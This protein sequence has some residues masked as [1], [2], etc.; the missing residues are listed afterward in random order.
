[1]TSRRHTFYPSSHLNKTKK[2]D[3]LAAAQMTNRQKAEEI[4]VIAM[5]RIK[6]KDIQ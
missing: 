4:E 6:S 5:A 2:Q 1:M 3:C